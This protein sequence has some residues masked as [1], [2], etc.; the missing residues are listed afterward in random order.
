M[1]RSFSKA[2]CEGK[3]KVQKDEGACI[4]Y[5]DETMTILIAVGVTCGVVS[6][7]LGVWWFNLKAQKR[8]QEQKEAM[9]LT[10][11]ANRDRAFSELED[12][13]DEDDLDAM[14]GKNARRIQVAKKGHIMEEETEKENSPSTGKVAAGSQDDKAAVKEEDPGHFKS[15][16]KGRVHHS[17]ECLA[18]KGL[19]ARVAPS[20][21]AERVG[22]ISYKSII[23]VYQEL[24]HWVKHSA[25]WSLK[26]HPSGKEFL[27]KI[28]D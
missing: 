8:E 27:K 24:G 20:T 16:K 12:E 13:D 3:L 7:C 6:A 28:E 9:Q 21:E 11:E 5:D 17:Y 22:I 10:E 15:R 18:H 2:V 25:G 1:S 26:S 14:M 23:K 19:R 4:I